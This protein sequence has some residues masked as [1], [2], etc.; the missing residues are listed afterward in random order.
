MILIHKDNISKHVFLVDFNVIKPD[1][2]LIFWTALIFLLV[3]G[4]L[5]RTAFRP[6][7]NAL[8][9][10]EEDIQHALD[11]AK[12]AREEV[13]G[14]KADNE[15]LLAEAREE[16]SKILKEAKEVKDAIIKEAKEKA[17]EEAQKI[18]VNATQEIEN[19]R[20]A[21]VTDLKNQAGLMALEIAEKLIRK[22]LSGDSAN[23]AFVKTLVN[24][25]K[26]N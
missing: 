6:I 15:K 3:W 4:F 20:M 11:E 17:K 25:I 7:Q 22:E 1:P 8:K 10:R 24:E 26:L 13:A 2:G 12:R 14:L 18:V 16:R 23:E 9:K 5:G 21:A 19:Q